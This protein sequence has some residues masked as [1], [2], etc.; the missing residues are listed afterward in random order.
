MNS[1][2]DHIE[3]LLPGAAVQKWRQEFSRDKLV[4]IRDAVSSEVILKW[5]SIAEELVE[6]YGVDIH[7]ENDG[8]PLDYRVVT[9]DVIRQHWRELYDFYTSPKTRDWV[10]NLTGDGHIFVS[11][12][13]KSSVNINSMRT[14][15]QIY[16][17]HT[18]AIPYTLLLFLTDVP[19][20]DGGALE[21]TPAGCGDSPVAIQPR[22]G[23]IVLMDGSIC[24]HRVA[25]LLSPRQRL[26]VPMVYPTVEDDS[27]PPGLD[28]YLYAPER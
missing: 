11:R 6:D 15:G 1:G 25:P 24:R 20:S 14:P 28:D 16:R 4:L 23:S 2:T 26:T 7:R 5:S 12:N 9:G 8:M 10:R 13:L 17:W 3:N 27:R 22:A 19:E 21:I 18:D